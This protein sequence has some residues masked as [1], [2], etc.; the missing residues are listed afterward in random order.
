LRLTKHG[1]IH[2]T[3][4]GILSVAA[5]LVI[6]LSSC[7]I[8]QELGKDEVLVNRARIEGIKEPEKRDAARTLIQQKPNKKLFG[9]WRFY[10]RAYNYG[11]RGDRRYVKKI[12][13]VFKENW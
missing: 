10:L 6:F 13:E 11:M 8:T 2:S 4:G 7:K 3:G 9:F 5:G 12:Q 1:V